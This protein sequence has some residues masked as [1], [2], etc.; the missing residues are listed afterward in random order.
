MARLSASS[1]PVV[2]VFTSDAPRSGKTTLARE[3]L[4][5]FSSNP[6]SHSWPCSAVHMSAILSQ[7]VISGYLWFE[8]VRG[9]EKYPAVLDIFRDFVRSEEW[10]GA[11]RF[12]KTPR[13]LV[14]RTLVIITGNCIEELAGEL[15]VFTNVARLEGQSPVLEKFLASDSWE[16]R[17]M[18]KGGAA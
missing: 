13:L 15:V 10:M 11:S 6:V 7:A 17:P 2:Y 8:D 12:I 5:Q 3:C 18:K 4:K 1:R 16:G 14:N 9:V